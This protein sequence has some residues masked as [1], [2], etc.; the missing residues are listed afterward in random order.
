MPPIATLPM[1][2]WP[3]RRAETDARWARLRDALR[4]EGFDAPGQL[5]RGGDLPSLWLSPDLLIGETCSQP[6]ATVLNGC[7]R[8]VATPVHHARGCGHGTYRSAVIRRYPGADMPVPESGAAVIAPEILTG[9]L[10][11]NEPGSMSGYVTLVYDCEDLGLPMPAQSEILWTGAHRESIRAV[12]KGRADYAVID[13][14]SWDLARQLEPAS[15]EVHVAGWASSRPGL[16][17]ITSL[18]T[19]DEELKRMRRAVMAA[20]EAVVLDSPFLPSRLPDRRP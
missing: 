13:C 3:E 12:S 1:Y 20:M 17:L 11:A 9:R 10:A 15:S 6:L 2:D 7:V 16:P 5:T 19:G 14:V 4:D 18:A 8:Y